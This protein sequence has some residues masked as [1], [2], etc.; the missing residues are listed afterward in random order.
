MDRRAHIEPFYLCKQLSSAV[1][2]SDIGGVDR[3][4]H[5]SSFVKSTGVRRRRGDK[6]ELVMDD[7]GTQWTGDRR[8]SMVE[9]SMMYCI[10]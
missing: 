8:T 2:S 1:K 5:G 9:A 6:Q 3:R 10:L 7:G 4:H